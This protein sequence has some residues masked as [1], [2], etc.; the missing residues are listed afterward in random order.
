MEIDNEAK[1]DGD[2]A[3]TLSEERGGDEDV[4]NGRGIRN[5]EGYPPQ[6]NR[7]A[8]SSQTS[9][10]GWPNLPAKDQAANPSGFQ[11]WIRF[12]DREKRTNGN[13]DLLS[14]GG[15]PIHWP[16]ENLTEEPQHWEEDGFSR[17]TTK[18]RNRDTPGVS[19]QRDSPSS[20]TNRFDILREDFGGLA[21]TEHEN[22]DSPLVSIEDRSKEPPEETRTA[23]RWA[24]MQDDEVTGTGWDVVPE[25]DEGLCREELRVESETLHKTA[26]KEEEVIGR[27]DSISETEENVENGGGALV[28]WKTVIN[29]SRKKF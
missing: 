14:G 19:T 4:L 18:S 2:L 9:D 8:R 11:A 3:N 28:I 12:R 16:Q 20:S 23:T 5:R 6:D 10:G 21:A 27:K 17:A 1:V 22:V 25:Q 13:N 7:A 29:S 24:D 15:S 26:T